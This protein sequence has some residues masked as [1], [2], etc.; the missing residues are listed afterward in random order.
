MKLLALDTSTE[1]CSAALLMAGQIC[2]RFVIAPRGHS[3]LILNMLETL[4]AEAGISLSAIDALA[5]GRGPGS[6]T[7][8]RIGVSVAQGIAFARDLP[9]VPVS[10]LA[11]LAQFCEAKKTLAAIDARMGEVYW[12]VYER[13]AEGLV[14]L[15]DSEQVCAPEAVPLV[16][17]AG[18]KWFGAGTGWG[19]YKDKL[20]ARLGGK[21][22]DWDAEYYPRASATA[23][24]AAAAFARGESIM[25]EQALP[26]YLRDNV[27]K[28]SSKANI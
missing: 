20:C 5:F 13:G 9:L 16:A 6:F 1:A 10:S 12:G 8:V 21:V 22:D 7:G 3:D 2:E 28:K 18:K 19:A 14:R 11:A 24:L 25:A 27:A 17:V 26:V 23:Q 15:M 4:L